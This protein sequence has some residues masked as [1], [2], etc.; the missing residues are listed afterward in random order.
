MKFCK[1][2]GQQIEDNV[3]FCPYCG[4]P[5]QAAPQPAVKERPAK[6]KEAKVEGPQP[7]KK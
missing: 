3:L 1:K 6:A 5:Q 2:C 4:T 7:L